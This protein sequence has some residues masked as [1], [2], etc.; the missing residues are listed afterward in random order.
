MNLED[1]VV[2]SKQR[3]Y[4]LLTDLSSYHFY[5]Y[6]PVEETFAFDC[7]IPISGT[8]EYRLGRMALSKLRSL[9]CRIH[10]D[11]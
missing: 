8:R 4:G 11:Y 9:S 6:D 5:S 1:Q 10:D 7:I 3:V 2:G